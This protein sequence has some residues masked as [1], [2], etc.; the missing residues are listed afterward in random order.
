MI[1]RN[2]ENNIGELLSRVCPILE[3]VHIV[4]TGSTDNTLPII[5]KLQEQYSNLH[6]HH[7][8]WVDDFAAARNYSLSR[9]QN[10]EWIFWLDGDD[11]IDADALR[12]FKDE[13]LDNPA[14]GAWHLPYQYAPNVWLNRERF[15]RREKDPVWRGAIHEFIDVKGAATKLYEPLAVIHNSVGKERDGT[16]NLRILRKEYEKD[17][18]NPR[19]AYYFGKE[20]FDAQQYEEAKKVLL[21]YLPIANYYDDEIG[22]RYRLGQIYLMEKSYD[23]ALRVAEPI[24]RLSGP[25]RNRAEYYYIFGEVEYAQKNPA[26]AASWYERCLCKPPKRGIIRQDLWTLSPI[27]KLLLCYRDLGEWDKVFHYI[28]KARDYGCNE[29]FLANLTSY[30]LHPKPNTDKAELAFGSN[31]LPNAY[32][33][34]KEPL[35]V[36]TGE[37]AKF[38]AHWTLNKHLP[39]LSN[40][41]D[42][43]A[44]D[45]TCTTPV[46]ELC[47]VIKPG[48]RLVTDK[49]VKNTSLVKETDGS[50][51]KVVGVDIIIPSKTSAQFA[52]MVKRCITSLRE[53]EDSFIAFNVILVESEHDSPVHV[54][55]DKTLWWS[56]DRNFNYNGALNMGIRDSRN[57]WVVLANNDVVFKPGWFTEMLRLNAKYPHLKSFSPWNDYDNWHPVRFPNVTTEEYII[58]D[59]IC[60]GMAGWCIVTKREVLSKITLSERVELWYS[61]NIYADEL[62]RIK[63]PHALAVRSKVDHLVSQTL[64]TI[65]Y[66]PAGDRQTYLAGDPIKIAAAFTTCRRPEVFH[67]AYHSFKLRCL[68]INLVDTIYVVDDNSPEEDKVEMKRSAPDAV[69][70]D[71]KGKGHVSSLNALLDEVLSKGYEYL[72]FMEDDFYFVRDENLIGRAVGIMKK[73][74]HIGQVL[75]NYNYS[76]SDVPLERELVVVCGEK[77]ED[78]DGVHYIHEWKKLNSD[79]WKEFLH[80]HPGK[81]AHAHWPHFSLNNGV[82]RLTAIREVGEFKEEQDFEFRYAVRYAE[83][84]YKTAFLPDINCLHLGKPRRGVLKSNPSLHTEMLQ[85][86]AIRIGSVDTAYTLNNSTR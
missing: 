47:R 4:D 28:P 66:T 43:I 19:T 18:S 69:F 56:E 83:R 9:C 25:E 57:D 84:G 49:E 31:A 12:K 14:V 37:Y 46:D 22:A 45:D 58:D 21:A 1:C 32:K 72:V 78:E 13:V 29:Q 27:I 40:S 2:E 24:Y 11:L 60:C 63:Q 17:A 64:N 68:D 41:I 36:N 75:F 20:L 81:T 16:R 44:F 23:E 73:N 67:R 34:G 50:Y 62:R 42:S 35:L 8:E 7:F 39:F 70:L 26:L 3:E 6:L 5:K 82:W 30:R 79:A 74:P 52:D 71:K 15:V 38:H 51:R 85:R 10:T 53:S 77:V 48:G 76:E 80:T 33:V 61:D 55:Q 59:R 65:N 86:H 54:G